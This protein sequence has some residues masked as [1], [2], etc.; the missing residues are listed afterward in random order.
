MRIRRFWADHQWTVIALLVA[1]AYAMG[2]WGWALYLA[3]DEPD[4]WKNSSFIDLLY[5]ALTLFALEG[6]TEIVG[7]PWQLEVARFLAP[8]LLVYTAITAFFSAFRTQVQTFRAGFYRNH[9]V[10]CGL[11]EKGFLIA[12][13][14]R[15]A[16]HKVILVEIDAGNGHIADARN[17]GVAVLIGN[18]TDGDRLA[19]ARLASADYV[20][21]VAGDD[22]INAEVALHARAQLGKRSRDHGLSCFVHISDPDLASF[23]EERCMAESTVEGFRLEIFNIFESGA[24]ALLRDY[25]VWRGDSADQAAAPPRPLVAGLGRLGQAVVVEMAQQ[26]GLG[27]VKRLPLTL[28]DEQASAIKCELEERYPVVAQHCD[29]H[30]VDCDPNSAQFIDGTLTLNNPS[31]TAANAVYVCIGDD[32]SALSVALG[33]RRHI[34]GRKIPLIVRT[35]VRAGLASLVE[36]DDERMQDPPIHVFSLYDRTCVPEILMRSTRERIAQ[37]IH[38]GYLATNR[39]LYGGTLPAGDAMQ[40]WEKLDEEYRESSRKQADHIIPKLRAIGC[41]IRHRRSWNAPVFRFTDDE[42]DL[43]ARAEHQ[44]WMN[45][46]LKLGWKYGEVRNNKRKIHPDLVA[47]QKLTD[48][49]REL[50]RDSVR[51]LPDYLAMSG[52]E[53]VREPRA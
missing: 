48:D 17:Q 49:R 16:G 36:T 13:A 29:L 37:A 18:A 44:R 10:V 41:R 45:D 27:Q 9:A 31:G 11:G 52:F 7:G 50:D 20:F 39:R 15:A 1:F 3:A 25:P 30:P 42:L 34:E 14:L 26:W 46:R 35:Q 47:W 12:S 21:A 22:G 8:A 33:L 19:G 5:R 43:L 2:V 38:D 4:V 40:P 53:V 6:A 24:Q 32:A 28:V 23:L 51:R